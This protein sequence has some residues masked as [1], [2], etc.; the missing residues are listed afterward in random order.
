MGVIGRFEPGELL[1]IRREAFRAAVE[2]FDPADREV[3][4]NLADD[5][6]KGIIA[7]HPGAQVTRDEALEVLAEIGIL[8]MKKGTVIDE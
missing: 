2:K 4:N 6:V 8:L 5:L 3:I 7:F 1:Q